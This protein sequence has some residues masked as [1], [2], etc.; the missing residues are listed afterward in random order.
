MSFLQC[1]PTARTRKTNYSSNEEDGPNEEDV[2]EYEHA[3]KVSKTVSD[4]RLLLDVLTR[5]RDCLGL[6]RNIDFS[7]GLLERIFDIDLDKKLGR[8]ILYRW[9]SPITDVR[10]MITEP[11]IHSRDFEESQIILQRLSHD[12]LR[13]PHDVLG[14]PQLVNSRCVDPMTTLVESMIHAGLTGVYDKLIEYQD[15][16]VTAALIYACAVSLGAVYIKTRFCGSDIIKMYKTKRDTGVR[17]YPK[18][19]WVQEVTQIL[20]MRSTK[21][22]TLKTMLTNAAE[23]CAY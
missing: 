12:L 20:S 2:Q 3:P 8:N 9:I 15:V 1:K 21:S 4:V 6:A 18:E 19:D 7:D 10:I 5:T 14:I 17:W 13:F 16:N 22:E 23:S 11:Y